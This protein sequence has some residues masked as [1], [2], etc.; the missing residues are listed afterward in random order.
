MLAVIALFSFTSCVD[1]TTKTEEVPVDGA[2]VDTSEV[3]TPEVVDTTSTV[4]VDVT[5]EQ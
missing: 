5:V 2:E 4:D 3:V 1:S